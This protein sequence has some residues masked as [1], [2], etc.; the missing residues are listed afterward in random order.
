MKPIDTHAHLI[1]EIKYENYDLD[2]VIKEGLENL[3]YIFNIGINIES[4]KEI[5]NLNKKYNR[6]KPIRL[7]S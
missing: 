4:S 5:I 6:L 1:T 3:S 7:L 2:N